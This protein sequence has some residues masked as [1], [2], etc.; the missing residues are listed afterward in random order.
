MAP[1]F[2][3]GPEGASDI[4]KPLIRCNILT[5]IDFMN[6]DVEGR[7]LAV[8]ESHD[9]SVSPTIIAIEDEHFNP[10]KPT[11]SETYNFLASKGYTL[12]GLAGLTLIWKLT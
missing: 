9:W 3:G 6:I 2:L 10:D 8:L 5:H 4:A 11:I 7:D 12:V 1:P